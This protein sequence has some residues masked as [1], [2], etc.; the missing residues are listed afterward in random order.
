MVIYMRM[1][2]IYLF[3]CKLWMKMAGIWG[4]DIWNSSHCVC[5]RVYP[6]ICNS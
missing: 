6:D 5:G 4:G 3:F 2:I 1:V